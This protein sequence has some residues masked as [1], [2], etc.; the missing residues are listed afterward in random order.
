MSKTVIFFGIVVFFI[1]SWLI[2][3]V[4][5]LEDDVD[6]S[7]GFNE[8]SIVVGDIKDYKLDSSG[9]EILELSTFSLDEK[10]RLWSESSL[11]EEMIELFPDF[12]EIKYFIENRIE[13]D[14]SFKNELLAH[15]EDVQENYLG[16][17]VTGRKAKIMLSNL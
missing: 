16:G 1:I 7:Y 8:K 14:G 12:S 15:V 17:G 4:D 13:D 6:V 10:K 5:N 2:G 9:N 3:F 11:K